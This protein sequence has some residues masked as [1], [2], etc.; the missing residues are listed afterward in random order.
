MI[1]IALNIS[2]GQFFP[3]N[4]T[5]ISVYC[6]FHVSFYVC[7]PLL[8]HQLPQ[9]LHHFLRAD[10]GHRDSLELP[11]HGFMGLRD[12]PVHGEV[13]SREGEVPG[14]QGERR[15][16]IIGS[17]SH[18]EDPLIG[19]PPLLRPPGHIVP[20]DH[21]LAHVVG[22]P[23]AVVGVEGPKN[24]PPVLVEGG[25][26]GEDPV[27]EL[28]RSDAP[29]PGLD[30]EGVGVGHQHHLKVLRGSGAEELEESEH[31]GSGGYLLH[32]AAYLAL[33]D[34]LLRQV[35]QH[36]LHVL[37]VA[38]RLVGVLQP[39]REVLTRGGLHHHVIAGFIHDGLIEVKED[40]EALVGGD[41]C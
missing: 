18:V 14:P 23:R 38:A 11:G 1:F 22:A 10:P 2:L 37:V 36:T 33:G 26:I 30:E 24:Q 20:D 12:Q 28:T 39:A 27:E 7:D 17:V 6:P 34:A 31:A 25:R 35:G 40:D 9:P 4:M 41:V 21:L 15:A 16:E 3:E 19:A 8:C 13:P 32:D 29:Q 5:F